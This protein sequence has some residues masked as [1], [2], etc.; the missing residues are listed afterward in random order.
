[1]EERDVVIL[2]YIDTLTIHGEMGP[3]YHD[4]KIWGNEIVMVL[5]GSA[6]FY[7]DDLCFPIQQGDV[8]VLSGYYSKFFREAKNLRV[9]SVYYHDSMINRAIR[10]FERMEGFQFL[11]VQAPHV[12]AYDD[13]SR[14]HI[15]QEQMDELMPLIA[16]LEL[17]QRTRLAGYEQAL[18]AAFL[19]LVT[20]ISRLHSNNEFTFDKRMA[21]V[22]HAATYVNLHYAEDLTLAE[23]TA[24]ACMSERHFT[25][26]F[27]EVFRC[28]PTQYIM[29]KRLSVAANLLE[30]TEYAVADI[31][32]QC[33]F[34]DISYFS[35]TF[36]TRYLLSPTAFRKERME[37]IRASNW[38]EMPV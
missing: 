14:L 21:G 36:R 27:K 12:L 6:E 31:A 15:T 19:L 25:R 26:K 9:V 2:Q 37:Q 5:E 18:N 10:A 1:M 16:R 38:Q 23:L 30:T 8:F 4:Y 20:L 29:R 11:F 33:G 3:L 13:E 17:E 34:C 24:V 7:R 35:K 22:V 32:T 28:S